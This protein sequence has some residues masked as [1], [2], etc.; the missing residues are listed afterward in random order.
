[1]SKKNILIIGASGGIGSTLATMFPDDRLFLHYNKNKPKG[2][3]FHIT[4]DVCD[5]ESVEK[6][7][8]EILKIHKRIDVVIIASGINSDGFAHKL[9][10]STW[11]EIINTNLIGTFNVIRSVLPSM[12]STRYG[13]IVVLS[14][15]VFQKPVMGTSAYSASKAGL[16]G[17]T[18]TVAVENAALGITCNCLALGY[19]EAGM[20]YKMPKEALEEVRNNIPMKRFGQVAEVKTAINFLIETEY[21]TGQTISINGGLY[22]D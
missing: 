21:L 7:V 5:F 12:R 2:E 15:I 4:A 18:R 9:K 17:I 14:S 11:Q 3:G 19:F 6:M 20:L 22:M 1:M 16:V 8:Q 10:P 13:R